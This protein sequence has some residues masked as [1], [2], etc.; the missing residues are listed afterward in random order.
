[1]IWCRPTLRSIAKWALGAVLL[2]HVAIAAQACVMPAFRPA[3][4]F[5]GAAAAPACEDQQQPVD[6]LCLAQCL[7]ADQAVDSPHGLIAAPPAVYPAT[8]PAPQPQFAAL[9]PSGFSSDGA[10]LPTGPPV[11]LRSLRLRI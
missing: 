11:Y 4:A 2:A 7:Q 9:A 3:A 6:L 5:P 8:Y 1:M 10:A